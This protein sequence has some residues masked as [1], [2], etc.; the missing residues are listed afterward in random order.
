MSSRP[1]SRKTT[2]PASDAPSIQYVKGVGPRI[3]ARLAARGIRTPDDALFFFPKGYE[4][5]RHIVPIR[6]LRPGMTA[7]VKGHVVGVHGSSKG[8]GGGRVFEVVLSD[9]TGR[10][11]AKWFHAHP[12]LRERFKVGGSVLFC[13]TVRSFQFHP[14]MHHPEILGEGEESDPVH[15]GRIVPVY[16]EI[17]GLHARTLRKIQWEIVHRHAAGVTEFLPRAMLEEAGVPPIHESLATLHF[18]PSGADAEKILS[19]ASPAQQRLIFGELFY[20]QWILAERRTGIL[21][22]KA[23]PLP[24]D[25][26]IVDEI[27]RRLPFVLTSAQR[28]VVNEILKDMAMPHPMHRLLQGDV[29]S[30]KT[31]VAWIAA[32]VAW[33]KGVQ[34]ALMA[35]TEILSDQHFTRIEALCRGLPVRVSLLTSSL[36]SRRRESLRREIREGETHIVVGTHALIQEGVDFARLGLAV[37]DEQHRFGVLQRAALRGKAPAAP[38]LLVMTA[39]PIPRT[40]AMTL[41]GDLDLSVIDEMP[42]GRTPVET[43]IVREGERRSAWDRVRK[44]L[45]SGGRIYIVLPLVEESEK[46]TLRD[47]TRTAE[48]VREAFPGIGVGLLHGRMKGE[49][50]DAVMKRFQEGEIRILVSTTV[51]EVGIDVPEATVIMIEHAERFGLSQLHQLRGRVGRGGRPS[52][53]FLLTGGPQGEDAVARLSVMEKTSDGFRIAEEDLKIRGPGDFAGVRQSGIPDL[54]FSDI[55]RDARMLSR[56]REIAAGLAARDPSLSLPEHAA[57]KR[58]IA[59]RRAASEPVD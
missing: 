20:I 48:K 27:K 55:V 7:A 19:F 8:F 32:M 15:M 43:R 10:M 30:G 40:L 57:L 11:S 54:V 42:P 41:Y 34:T 44:E 56:A 36:S 16:P 49:E 4:D 13:G 6:M 14:E 24:W 58:W 51:V 3:A 33:R 1:P 35:P 12:S 39:T 45:D 9:G 26:E 17:E 59:A 52:A 50:K 28:R 37:V 2:D 5:R 25:R 38:H 46:L 18:P 22:E 29:G 47:A 23:V 31:I 21:K 53:C